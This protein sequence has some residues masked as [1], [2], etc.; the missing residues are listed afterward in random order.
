M[1]I[2]IILVVLSWGSLLFLKKQTI[3]RFSPAAILVSFILTTITLCNSVLKLWEIRGN[4]QEKLLG[5]LMFILGPFLCAT[6]WVFRLTF[7]SF[8]L[9][10]LLNLAINYVFAYPLTSFFEKKGIYKLKRM[11]NHYMYMVT[12]S[13]SIIIYWYQSLIENKFMN[14][15]EDLSSHRFSGKTNDIIAKKSL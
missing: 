3:L 6:L 10:M 7:R 14:K 2:R 5:D 12:I 8:P 11:K 4:K 9:Y 15:N 1:P 13:Y